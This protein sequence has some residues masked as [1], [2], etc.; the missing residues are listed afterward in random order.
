M[1]KIAVVVSTAAHNNKTATA[2][3]IVKTIVE[4]EHDLAGVFFYQDGVSN[5]NTIASFPS[6]EYQSLTQWQTLAN[7]S[8]AKLHLCITA[9]EKRG[10]SD[11]DINNIDSS[12]IV[13]GLGELVELTNLCDRVLQL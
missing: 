13:S 4:S 10:M 12:F 5:A 1:A 9:A 6:D 8:Q 3:E 2:I 11:E 7:E